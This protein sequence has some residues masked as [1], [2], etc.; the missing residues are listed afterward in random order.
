M[1]GW[2]IWVA[3]SRWVTYQ[4]LMMPS[5]SKFD[6]GA[7]IFLV[8]DIEKFVKGEPILAT[9]RKVWLDVV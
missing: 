5:A 6:Q 3:V 9:H 8:G 2:G 7:I 1:K 4:S